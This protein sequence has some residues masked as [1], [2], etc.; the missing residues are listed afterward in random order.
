MALAASQGWT[1]HQ[2][3]VNTI[4]LHGFLKEEVFLEQPQG[5]EVHDPKS[6]VCRLKKDLYGLKQAPRAWYE[7]LDAYM[8]QMGF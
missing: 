1:L 4:F 8:Q 2:M 7:R 3:D 6:H 5:F